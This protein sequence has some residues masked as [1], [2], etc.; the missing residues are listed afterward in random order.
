MGKIGDFK[1]TVKDLTEAPRK[2]MVV[3]VIALLV[4]ITALLMSMGNHAR[5]TWSEA[6]R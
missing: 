5:Y 1:T 3:A 2:V 4:G 6:T